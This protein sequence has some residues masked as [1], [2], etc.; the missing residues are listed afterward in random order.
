MGPLHGYRIIEVAGRGPGPFAGMMLSDMGANVLRVDRPGSGSRT[1]S[2]KPTLELVN[3]GRR[4]IV[5]DLKHPDGAE[6]VLRLV[7]QAHAVFEGYRPG[8]AERLGIGPDICLARNP[9]L[10]YARAT[11][12]GQTGPLAQVAGH[13]INYIA[14]AGALEPIGVADLPPI[15]PLNLVGDYG[16]GGAMLAF[17]IVCALLEAQGSGRGQVIDAAMVDGAS[18]L[19]IAIHGRRLMG[20]WTDQRGANYLDGGAPFYSTYETKDG[21]YVSVGCIED[22]FYSAFIEAIGID[23]LDLPRQWDKSAWPATKQRL[24]AVFLTK[25]RAEWEEILDARDVCFAP[26]L[27]I[28][29]VSRHSHHRARDSFVEVDGVVHPAPAPRFSRTPPAVAGPPSRPG[30]HTNAALADWGFTE[31][32]IEALAAAETI[33]QT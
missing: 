5:V 24:A 22:K 11:G 12:W 4:S 9:S 16:G 2:P 13:D 8:V 27:G 26:V 21:K 10:V 25:T 32:E 15:P 3:R 18:L 1:Q 19:M 29:E 30:E 33:R 23:E 28:G 31:D 14:L 20:A 6:V 7:E 17:G